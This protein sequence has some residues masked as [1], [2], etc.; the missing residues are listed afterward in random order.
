MSRRFN[1]PH[2]PAT[3]Q[4]RGAA[5]AAAPTSQNNGELNRA[6][7]NKLH[8]DFKEFWCTQTWAL[9][10]Q[11]IPEVI[12]ELFKYIDSVDL[13]KIPHADLCK[14]IDEIRKGHAHE[15]RGALKNGYR[16]FTKEQNKQPRLSILTDV[17]HISLMANMID[18][19]YKEL[20][21]PGVS[22]QDDNNVNG[23]DGFVHV[24]FGSNP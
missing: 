5:A 19:D 20:G 15:N 21:L 3:F 2:T 9:Q 14:E 7:V 22:F 4:A 18:T 10:R 23:N 11:K 6:L 24:N 13:D 1:Q 8:L 12:V 16:A 17:E